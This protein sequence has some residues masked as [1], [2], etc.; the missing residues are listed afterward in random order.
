ME[1][2]PPYTPMPMWPHEPCPCCG[3]LLDGC[4]T[5]DNK[6]PTPGMIGICNNCGAV[7]KVREDY[8]LEVGTKE[9]L[10]KIWEVEQES[11]KQTLEHLPNIRPA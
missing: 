1:K 6:G 2:T 5:R 8:Q 9:D 10:K 4:K 3:I 11:V 7:F